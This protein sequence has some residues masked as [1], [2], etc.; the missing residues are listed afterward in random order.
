MQNGHGGSRSR[1]S[2]PMAL[3]LYYPRFAL[4]DLYPARAQTQLCP[5]PGP[6]RARRPGRTPRDAGSRVLCYTDGCPCTWG[7]CGGR[8]IAPHARRQVP[9]T[10]VPRARSRE[11][12]QVGERRRSCKES[13]EERDQGTPVG[14]APTEGFTA[15]KGSQVGEGRRRHVRKQGVKRC[16]VQLDSRVLSN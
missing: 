3:S 11:G 10:Q 14:D 12:S 2:C 9:S 7:R 16:S 5:A 8:W 15:R 6:A 4:D 1:A 13:G